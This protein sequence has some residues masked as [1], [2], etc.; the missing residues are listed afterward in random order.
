M[1]TPREPHDADPHVSEPSQP[2]QPSQPNDPNEP[3]DATDPVLE[4]E[5]E[6]AVRAL[7]AES[8]AGETMPPDVQQRLESTLD[9]LAAARRDGDPGIDPSDDPAHGLAANPAALMPT[10]GA[11]PPVLDLAA[12]RRRRVVRG[13]LVAAAAV[14]VVGIGVQFAEDP[15]NDMLGATAES[16]PQRGEDAAAGD[17]A[18]GAAAPDEFSSEARGTQRDGDGTESGDAAGSGEAGGLS[19]A[20]DTG[21]EEQDADFEGA[22]RIVVDE[23]LPRIRAR[24]LR[25]DL[26]DL[27]AAVLPAPAAADYDR[28]AL[29]APKGF[30]CARMRPGRGVL[31]GVRY[32]GAPA[33]VA[34]RAPLGATQVA[35]VL[36]CGTNDVLRSV[37]IPAPQ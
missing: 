13:L 24:H 33:L 1:P 32:D 15:G 37:T 12:R 27:Q 16:D 31:V 35:E 23:P 26:I 18:A 17:A 21:I 6:D 34:Y 2:S 9:D 11:T 5:R 14:V 36:Q 28:T 3:T 22:E 7:I 30:T 20:D 8:A 19:G 29:R 25:D 4:P 10:P